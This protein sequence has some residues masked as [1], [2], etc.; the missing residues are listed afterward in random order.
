MIIYA[1]SFKYLSII[2]IT[3]NADIFILFE[4]NNELF[5]CIYI[6][7]LNYRLQIEIYYS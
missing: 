3:F 5:F 1:L 2:I 7:I 4:N 6:I